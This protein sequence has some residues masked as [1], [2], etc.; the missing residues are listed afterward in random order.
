MFCNGASETFAL[1]ANS[2]LPEFVQL[3][4]H[5]LSVVKVGTHFIVHKGGMNK[6]LFHV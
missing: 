3:I 2:T 1:V 6:G 5:G 4:K